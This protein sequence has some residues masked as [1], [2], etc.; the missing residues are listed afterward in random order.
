MIDKTDFKV[1][2]VVCTEFA[3][4][5]VSVKKQTDQTNQKKRRQSRLFHL[6]FIDVWIWRQIRVKHQAVPAFL[7]RLKF[8]VAEGNENHW[9]QF[10]AWTG[11]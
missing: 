5:A 4:R 1:K 2:F 11:D 3:G 7:S 10:V 6:L 8:W 9:K